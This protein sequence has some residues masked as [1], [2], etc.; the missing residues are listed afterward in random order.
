MYQTSMGGRSLSSRLPWNSMP[1][2]L[3][4][5]AVEPIPN[6]MVSRYAL[7]TAC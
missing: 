6:G 1:G 7:P 4:L 5:Y 2:R 3:S